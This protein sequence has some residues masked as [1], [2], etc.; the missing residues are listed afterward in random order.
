MWLQVTPP[1][2]TSSLLVT[3]P[4]RFDYGIDGFEVGPFQPG[5]PPSSP[6]V[7]P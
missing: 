1:K 3:E 6:P 4:L 5:S 7:G 2:T